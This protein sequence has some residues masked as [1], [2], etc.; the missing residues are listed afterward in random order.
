MKLVE[1]KSKHY[2]DAKRNYIQKI[3]HQLM[4]LGIEVSDATLPKGCGWA[5]FYTEKNETQF[6]SFL[7]DLKDNFH[8]LFFKATYKGDIYMIRFEN[9]IGTALSMIKTKD[10]SSRPYE[11]RKSVYDP[12]QILKLIR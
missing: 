4:L 9:H 2:A 7:R 10:F 12:S 5:E 3:K 8:C 1:T 6:T 11:K